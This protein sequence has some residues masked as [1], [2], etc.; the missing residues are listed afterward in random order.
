MFIPLCGAIIPCSNVCFAPEVQFLVC[1]TKAAKCLL[2]KCSWYGQTPKETLGLLSKQLR[3]NVINWWAGFA[4]LFFSKDKAHCGK[5]RLKANTTEYVKRIPTDSAS[6]GDQTLK[7]QGADFVGVRWP[8]GSLNLYWCSMSAPVNSSSSELSAEQVFLPYQYQQFRSLNLCGSQKTYPQ[9]SILISWD[10][11]CSGDRESCQHIIRSQ[12]IKGINQGKSAS[13]T[14][15]NGCC[16][17]RSWRDWW[18]RCACHCEK[19]KYEVKYCGGSGAGFYSSWCLI[20]NP[21][22][23]TKIIH[24]CCSRCCVFCRGWSE[25]G[26]KT[27]LQVKNSFPSAEQVRDTQTSA[28]LQVSLEG[29]TTVLLP[30]AKFQS[31]SSPSG[32]KTHPCA[33]MWQL[34]EPGAVC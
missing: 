14:S 34:W 33:A 20:L 10:D 2:S 19:R 15:D 18:C 27:K 31:G 4:I 22:Q 9:S 29:W 3:Q 8:R 17:F 32:R 23:Y 7:V 11:A 28:D 25:T 21:D 13:L 5:P 1:F 26:E 24:T 6:S 16:C 30:R 12:R